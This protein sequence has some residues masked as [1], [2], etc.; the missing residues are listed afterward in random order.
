M[1][2]SKTLGF[3]GNSNI[4]S[5]LTEGKRNLIGIDVLE[6]A[7]QDLESMKGWKDSVEQGIKL[8]KPEYQ[9]KD[10]PW[11]GAAN[12]KSTILTE[13]ANEF[14]NRAAMEIMREPKLVKA[15]IIG[16][17]TIKNV[18]DR[19]AS[20][21][22]RWKQAV[23]STTEQAQS[24]DKNDPQ[25]QELIKVIEEANQKISE[26]SA[27]IQSS[28][29]DIRSK[30]ERADRVTELMNYQINVQMEEW[31]KDQ[32]RMLYSLPNVGCMF[33]KTDYDATLGRCVS[34]IVG[35]PNFI[36]NQQT[37]SLKTCR[38]FTHI[39]AFSK[40]EVDIRIAQKLWIDADIYPKE[41]KGDAGSDEE[42]GADATEDNDNKFYEQYCWADLDGDNIEEPYVIT[43]HYS[44]GKVVRIVARYDEDTIIVKANGIKPMPLIMA[45]RKM[46]EMV[47][48]NNE[49]YGT[50]EALPDPTDLTPYS[51]VR[52]DPIDILTKYGL[53]PSFDGSFLDVGF[54]HM[55]GSM[56]LGVNKTTNDLLNSGTLATSQTG[57]VAKGFRRK[58]GNFSLTPGTFIQTEVSPEV[59]AGSIMPLPFKEP[60]GT[61]FQLNEKMENTARSFSAS[62]DMAGQIQSN[63]APTTALAIIQESS[64]A[65]TAHMGMIIDSMSDE[66][67]ILYN[68]NRSYFDPEEYQKIV[69]DSEA[70][71]TDDF[72]SDNI[73][74]SCS[75]NS[76]M[77]SRSQ[78]MMLSEAEM[79]QIP[80]VIQAGG[81]P[82]PIVKNYY[83]R[84]GSENFDEIFSSEDERS[85]EEKAQVKSMQ[86]QQEYAN[87]MAEQQ[88]NM[89]QLQTELLKS[90][91]ERKAFEATIAAKE[92]N[93][94]IDKIFE[95][96]ENIKS[97]TLLN[98][99][100]AETEQVTNQIN[101][102]TA[103]SDILND[104]AEISEKSAM[105]SD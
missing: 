72:D 65:H 31:R 70:V 48:G 24:V 61:L 71:F 45:Q 90:G 8:C 43:V 102:Y 55:I 14:G 93:A 44:T 11:P 29:S 52:I 33:K 41:D 23:E 12:F 35:Y 9:P 77:S 94:K 97:Q 95:E 6:R 2:L 63:T 57:V 73:S 96:I 56:T 98:L 86:Q 87:Q 53:I 74:V 105:E 82:A 28:K 34:K 36:V 17:T 84:I 80:M 5:D 4:A 25:Y 49:K 92:T 18:I 99:E 1:T 40:A 83:K 50:K 78:R 85:P 75:A 32:K 67:K 27:E 38:S 26:A 19:K 88:L 15:S 47:K 66:F 64:V 76:E 62:V 58:G 22:S 81:N 37:E 54:Y 68:L 7:S 104:Q 100:K 13:A 20:E 3:I 101:T 10:D 89:I 60:S 42:S 59:M 30:N 91:E 69:G 103:A 79:A 46:A 16:L 39:L 51:I 21:V